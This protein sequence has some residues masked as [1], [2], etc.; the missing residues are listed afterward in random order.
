LIAAF[1]TLTAE[2]YRHTGTTIASKQA[3]SQA[4][5]FMFQRPEGGD[6]P[7]VPQMYAPLLKMTARDPAKTDAKIDKKAKAK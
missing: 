7:S 5:W 1:Q 4:A 3:S 6:L 2:G